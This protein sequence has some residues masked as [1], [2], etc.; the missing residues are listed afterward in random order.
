[1]QSMRI[2]LV[3]MNNGVANQATRCFR[4]LVDAF[5][6]RVRERNPSLDVTFTHV[7]PRN[8]GELPPKDTDLLL[9]SGGPGSPYDGFD[10]PWCT[11]FRGYI[12]HIVE[13]N[14]VDPT[15]A[16]KAL[17]I[18]HSFQLAVLHTAIATMEQR[19]TKKFGLMTAYMTED[20]EHAD[21][22]RSFGYRLFCWEHR[23]WEAIDLDAKRLAELHGAVLATETHASHP[24]HKYKGD[25]LLALRFAPGVE[26]TQ[27]HPEADKP[28]IMAWVE[29]PE[30]QEAL[31]VAYGDVLL[32]KMK[33]SMSNP[34]RLAKTFALLIPGWLTYRFNEI[35]EARGYR[36]IE[37]PV[38]GDMREFDVAV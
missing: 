7:Q 22:L 4:R 30:S 19:A 25:A 12:D 21:F 10:A 6:R 37:A 35:A 18:C 1:M 13:R 8:L 34:E 31:R 5:G 15:S 32:D 17:L 3:D 27:F 2:C 9:S 20:G 24:Q 16:P 26:G 11:G 33:A 36:P 14:I 23:N 28:G 29:K 38:Q